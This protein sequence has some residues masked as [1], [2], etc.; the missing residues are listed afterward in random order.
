ML[1]RSC[2]RM[3]ILV[4]APFLGATLLLCGLIHAQVSPSDSSQKVKIAGTPNDISVIQHIVFIVK[5]NRTFD[6][7]FGTYPGANGATTAKVSTGQTIN[8]LH[9]PDPPPRDISGHGW[10]DAKDGVNG[11]NMDMFDTIA[12]ANANSDLLGLSQLTQQDIPN[13]FLYAQHF[14]LGDNM[15]SSLQGA[16]FANHLYTVGAQS[17]GAFTV[18]SPANQNSWGCDANP[19]TSVF[20]WDDDDIVTDPFPCLE[21]NTLPDALESAGVSWT[22]YSPNQGMPGYTYSVLDGINHIRNGPLWS[23]VVSDSQFNQDAKTGSLP[24]VSWITTADTVNEHPPSSACGGENWTVNTLNTLMQGPAWSTT[25]VFIVWDDFGGF[26]DHVPPPVVDKFGLGPR[27]PLLVISPY[28]IAGKITH[29]QYEFSSVLKFI[30]ERF[31][32]PPLTSRDA[33]ANDLTDAF[34]FNQKP[35]APFILKQRICPFVTPNFSVGTG[36]IGKA[37]ATV[38]LK[39]LNHATKAITMSGVATT[40]DF[41]QTNN[42]P[43]TMAPGAVCTVNL[44][45]TPTA[46][47]PRT[48]TVT[49]T[50]S[51]ASSPQVTNLTG[52]AT[53]VS[54]SS[55]PSFGTVVIGAKSTQTVTLSNTGTSTLNI[56]SI[57][58][59]GPFT[60]VNTCG[61][62]LASGANCKITVSFVPTTSG[63]LYGDVIVASDDAGSPQTVDVQ[64]IGQ[65]IKFAPNKLTFAGQ[66]VGTTSSPMTLTLSNAS[67]T[68]ELQIGTFTP[69]GDFASTNNC[70]ESLAPKASCTVSV[71]FTPTAKGARTGS[72]SVSSSDF[73][74]PQLIKLSGTGT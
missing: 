17:G 72:I 73:K 24:A 38:P 27:V 11:G 35:L 23:H 71:T 26:Y 40:S 20:V 58:M 7:Y 6:H 21:F 48:G 13:Y 57:T 3:R 28:A 70:P 69:S 49:F 32:I 43:P 65:T 56:S 53:A 30:E 1:F 59:R 33:T 74:S 60:Q 34:D 52:M 68:D 63:L 8:L 10:F 5:E 64:G 18:P 61:S 39:F 22:F 50:D 46:A 55:L 12:G 67:A 14:V 42:C 62:S 9:A 66:A 31:G 37:N 19:G 29:T 47:G 15:F 44:S 54:L 51:D 41:S 36:V 4:A 25:A 45:F 16:S 2:A